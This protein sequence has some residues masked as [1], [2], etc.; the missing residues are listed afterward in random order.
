MSADAMP[1]SSMGWVASLEF[2][3]NSNRAMLGAPANL[4]IQFFF[5]TLSIP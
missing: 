3:T 4:R 5:P 1:A 2:F